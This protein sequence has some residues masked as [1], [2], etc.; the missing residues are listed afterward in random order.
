MQISLAAGL[1]CWS[2]TDKSIL[3]ESQAELGQQ[4]LALHR[5]SYAVFWA[6]GTEAAAAIL[7][8]LIATYVSL[9]AALLVTAVPYVVCLVLCAMMLEPNAKSLTKEQGLGLSRAGTGRGSGL[10]RWN[11]GAVWAGAGA[12]VGLTG[13]RRRT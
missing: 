7:G 10:G 2:G 6:Q 9:R 4:D 5:E 3:Y 12:G 13:R 11:N 1:A 8:G